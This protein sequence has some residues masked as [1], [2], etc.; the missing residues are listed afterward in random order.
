MHLVE[1]RLTERADRS[2]VEI[3]DALAARLSAYYRLLE[4]WNQTIN[5]TSLVDLDRAVD[6][7]LLEPVAAAS[8]LPR[9]GR[10]IDLGSGGGSPAIPL[11]LACGST[12]LVMVESRE[13][14]CA[15]LREVI[16][17]MELETVARVE[18]CRFEDLPTRAGFHEG[19]DVVSVRALRLGPAM[20][21]AAGLLVP[22]GTLALFG[23]PSL[24][25]PSH[26]HRFVEVGAQPLLPQS[27]SRLT[28]LRRVP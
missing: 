10:L 24:E 7:L 4:H 8:R 16:R 14:K 12:Q 23:G 19:F 20:A 1:N 17:Q 15:F 18:A 28:I 5:L 21:A 26:D 3:P 6:R 25:P 27:T 11:A 13:R 9:G 22:G 2:G